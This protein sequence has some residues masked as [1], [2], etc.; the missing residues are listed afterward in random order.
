MDECISE[1]SERFPCRTKLLREF[2]QLFGKLNHRYPSSLYLYGSPGIGKTS[3]LL[4]FLNHLSIKHT[5]IDCIE[6]YT[7]KMLY[8]T[9][10]NEFND[11]TLSENNNF[12][13]YVRCDTMD[14]FIEQLAELDT[15]KPYVIVL[16]NYHRLK[17]TDAN[18][19]PVL[20][21]LEML[22]PNLNICC[23]LI[24]S[25]TVTHHASQLSCMP[26]INIH[27]EQYSKSELFRILMLQEKH[28]RKTIRNLFASDGSSEV[29]RHHRL[30]II[31]DLSTEFFAGYFDAF[32]N[33]FYT[34][35]RNVKELLYLSN[36][37][38]PIYCKPVIDGQIDKNDVRK[39]WKNMELP[40]KTA[41]ASIYC[42]VEHGNS[43][44][45]RIFAH[46]FCIFFFN[47]Y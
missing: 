29:E 47:S 2:Y 31:N 16:R 34:V 8:E 38:L 15:R 43:Q 36:A 18:I 20:M 45:V 21:R 30:Q 46:I 11:H 14:D 19:L 9:I 6:Y 13:N 37:N 24:G 17:E 42:R 3:L 25:K 33:V 5:N 23:I 12:E 4:Q 28:L 26:T 10:L 41:M 39:L 1:I 32:L 22:V 35:C 27:C 40:F 44:M 7:P